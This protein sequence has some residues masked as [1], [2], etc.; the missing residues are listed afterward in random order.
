[1]CFCLSLASRDLRT[2]SSE[3]R[4]QREQR[5][6]EYKE[7]IIEPEVLLEMR[8]RHAALVPFVLLPGVSDPIDLTHS[9]LSTSLTYINQEHLNKHL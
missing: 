2:P 4:H 8:C 3:T 6:C 5:L 7:G 9:N 1:M